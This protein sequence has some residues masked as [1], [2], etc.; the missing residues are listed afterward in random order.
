MN[1][2]N[3]D[4][5]LS[6]SVHWSKSDKKAPAASAKEEN[7]TRKNVQIVTAPRQRNVENK[8]I[9]STGLISAE[10]SEDNGT[11]PCADEKRAES[12]NDVCHV[13]T[14]M[15]NHLPQLPKLFHTTRFVSEPALASSPIPHA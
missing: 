4:K 7:K 13:S 1:P 14:A 3:S 8:T 6:S 11:N 10:K 2:L 5:V 12:K 15:E 9:G